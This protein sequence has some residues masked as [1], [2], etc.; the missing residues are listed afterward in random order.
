MR[1][2]I[3]LCAGRAEVDEIYEVVRCDE[4]VRRLE[5]SVHQT[6]VMGG[7]QS[8]SGLLHDGD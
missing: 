7:V 2:R 3:P 1:A 5:V 6:D 4:N 8:Q